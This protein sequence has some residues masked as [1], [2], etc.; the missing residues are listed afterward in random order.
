MANPL[1]RYIVDMLEIESGI[2][3]GLGRLLG[4]VENQGEVTDA[5]GRFRT[6]ARGQRDSLEERLDRIPDGDSKAETLSSSAP[7]T[8]SGPRDKNTGPST[9]MAFQQLF[10]AFSNAAFGY[11]LLHTRAHRFFD[12]TPEGSTGDIAQRHS[13]AYMEAAQAIFEMAPDVAIRELDQ[14]G[15]PCVCTCPSCGLGICLCWHTHAAAN[16]GSPEDKGIRIRTPKPKSEAERIGLREGDTVLT[17]DGQT[18]TT[19]QDLNQI[20]NKHDS[21]DEVI[22]V[23]QRDGG[24]RLEVTA[25]RP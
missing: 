5:I 3:E 4:L 9:S 23:F 7:T 16:S 15:R 22:L 11:G 14:E 25:A 17:L 2:E 13:Q 21:G 18:I 19:Y 20:L 12:G 1:Q 10:A 6:M 24:E 8:V